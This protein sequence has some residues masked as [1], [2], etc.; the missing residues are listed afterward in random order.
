MQEVRDWRIL[1]RI[2]V[3]TTK[4]ALIWLFHLGFA[5]PFQW[6]LINSQLSKHGMTFDDAFSFSILDCSYSESAFST[7]FTYPATRKLNQ[8]S[9]ILKLHSQREMHTNNN[10]KR[11]KNIEKTSCFLKHS[12]TTKQIKKNNKK[13]TQT[14]YKIH[15]KSR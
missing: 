8:N 2:N 14:N 5:A 15:K 7:R 1:Q 11:H 3:I 13:R 10:E 6:N 4:K 9:I 12:S